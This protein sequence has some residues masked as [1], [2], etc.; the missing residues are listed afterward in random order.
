MQQAS[1]PNHFSGLAA[2]NREQLIGTEA[3][4]SCTVTVLTEALGS[5]T[6][7][8]TSNGK[9]DVTT[10]VDGYTSAQGS[11]APGTHCQT[12]TLTVGAEQNTRDDIFECSVESTEY[13][14]IAQ[15]ITVHLKVFSK[16]ISSSD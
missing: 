1:S 7:M 2:G 9:L 4:I 16:Y 12:A 8:R 5:V 6:W 15:T 10:G 14:K 11:F 13:G 3:V